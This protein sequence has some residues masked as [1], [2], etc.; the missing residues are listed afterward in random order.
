MRVHIFDNTVPLIDKIIEVSRGMALESLSVAGSQIQKEVR[1]SFRKNTHHWHQRINAKTGK[2]EIFKDESV[3][4]KLGY[5]MSRNTGKASNP[6]NMSSM[7]T[8]YLMDKSMTVVVAGRHP[9]FVPE[10]RRDGMLTGKKFKRVGGVSQQT[11][12][13]LSK[14]NFGGKLPDHKWNGGGSI[15][16]FAGANYVAR[17]F[18]DEGFNASKNLVLESM[19]KRYEKLLHKAV[20]NAKITTSHREVS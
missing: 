18:I 11:F 1:K 4:R 3:S 6:K 13:I 15:K 9:S 20:N 14:L 12:D 2:R 17:N 5:R 7:I 19:T 16:N 8:S 10:E